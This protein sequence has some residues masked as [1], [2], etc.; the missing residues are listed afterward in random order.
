MEGVASRFACLQDDDSTDWV[1]PKT[2]NKNK[3][4]SNGTTSETKQGAAKAKKKNQAN[5]EAKELQQLAF[6]TSNKKTKTKNKSKT[7]DGSVKSSNKEQA[8]YEAWKE[9][10]E[11]VRILNFNRSSFI[12][13]WVKCS[14]TIKLTLERYVVNMKR[15]NVYFILQLVN[16]TYLHDVEKAL[17]L[18]KIDFEEHKATKKII[19]EERIR[20]KMLES[21][22]KPKTM[23][24]DQFNQ[25][26]PQDINDISKGTTYVR[27]EVKEP[28]EQ[29][30]SPKDK[31]LNSA[32][33]IG[34]T[35]TDLSPTIQEDVGMN[36]FFRKLH[37]DT[38]NMVNMEEVLHSS[39]NMSVVN[40]FLHPN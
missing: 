2:K 22:K 28:A 33:N 19:E 12:A 13:N 15:F 6:Q 36:D 11:E 29:K 16:D 5:N 39:R 37:Q 38:V 7:K 34:Q 26:E 35:A 3:S 31:V 17:L 1:Q 25:L 9:K 18:S 40:S 4:K 21:S 20:L 24:L 27:N 30:Y 14:K 23:S 8:Q 32:A 10:D